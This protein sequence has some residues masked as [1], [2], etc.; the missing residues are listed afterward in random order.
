[1]IHQKFSTQFNKRE[2]ICEKNKEHK[3]VVG[4]IFILVGIILIANNL[5]LIPNYIANAL[6]SWQMLLITIGTIIIF[7][8]KKFISGLILIA[9]GTIFMLHKFFFFTA[10]QWEL[11][12]P[13]AFIFVGVILILNVIAKQ[14]N[15]NKI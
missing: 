15:E 8:K 5:N 6:I 2:E 7:T 3:Y 11:I 4:A 13:A 14:N 1:M 9:I 12:W 10:L